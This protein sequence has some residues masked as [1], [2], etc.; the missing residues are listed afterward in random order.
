[1]L[2][3]AHAAHYRAF[4]SRCMPL[5]RCFLGPIVH[6][7]ASK[8]SYP[9]SLQVLASVSMG[10]LPV[11]SYLCLL[12]RFCSR[13]GGSNPHSPAIHGRRHASLLDDVHFGSAAAPRG[14]H[15]GCGHPGGHSIHVRIPRP[16]FHMHEL[17]AT[18]TLCCAD[19]SSL[20][21]RMNMSA[22]SLR[23]A[24]ARGRPR[25]LRWF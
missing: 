12:M 13:C 7:P 22:T 18:W 21:R 3:A 16:R 17:R 6:C 15:C 5:V 19:C 23:F 2:R 25:T 24:H 8:H 20:S 1:M 11:D 4:S 9:P 14:I 10:F